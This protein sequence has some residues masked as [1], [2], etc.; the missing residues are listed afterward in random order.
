MRSLNEGPVAFIIY[1]AVASAIV[2]LGGILFGVATIKAR[3]FSHQLGIGCII[4]LTAAG[5]VLSF[6]SI[7]GVEASLCPGGRSRVRSPTWLPS[8]G[9]QLSCYRPSACVDKLLK[10]LWRPQLT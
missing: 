2:S 9:L 4:V 8:P 10:P 6:L 7:P 3:T 5:F 1:F